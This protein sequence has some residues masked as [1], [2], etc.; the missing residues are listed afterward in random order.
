[1]F[2]FFAFQNHVKRS[3]SVNVE[4]HVEIGVNW[5]FETK[6]S[7]LIQSD[8]EQKNFGL[9]LFLSSKVWSIEKETKENPWLLMMDIQKRI[10]HYKGRYCPLT[11]NFLLLIICDLLLS[12]RYLS[13]ILCPFPY[14]SSQM[15]IGKLDMRSALSFTSILDFVKHRSRSVFFSFN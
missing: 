12:C 14:I 2:Y 8:Y 6:W 3:F 9:P 15:L 4:L 10:I 5:K 1:M 13:I 11:L 7:G